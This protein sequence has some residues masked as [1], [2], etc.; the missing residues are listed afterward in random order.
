MP[1]SS[2]MSEVEETLSSRAE[3]I[4]RLSIQPYAKRD[5][6]DTL[7]V[8]R[9]TV[10]RG[11]RDLEVLGLIERSQSGLMST[12]Y[13]RLAAQEYRMFERRVDSVLDAQSVLSAL[14]PD[15]EVDID[16][17]EGAEIV[18]A[19]TAAPHIPGSR[20]EDA[21]READ[22]CRLLSRAYSHAES[23]DL[24]HERIVRGR[25]TGALVFGSEVF[26]HLRSNHAEKLQEWVATGRFDLFA[27]DDLP[28]GLFLTER[29]QETQVCLVVY[30]RDNTIAGLIINDSDAAVEWGERI[31]RAYEEQA[32]RVE[33]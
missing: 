28:F 23:V 27:A 2:P 11:I 19:G 6:V 15:A 31:Y 14:A 30:D 16:V 18:A 4:E 20:L 10:D 8:S 9:S 12:L 5:L 29:T 21:I 26:D 24:V 22:R 32:E 7:D 33:L 13:G 25:M 17:L 1:S 3:W